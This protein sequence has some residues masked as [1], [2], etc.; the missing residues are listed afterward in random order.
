MKI[1]RKDLNIQKNQCMK[2]IYY[3]SQETDIQLA[4]LQ[5]VLRKITELRK[6]NR[7]KQLIEGNCFRMRENLVLHSVSFSEFYAK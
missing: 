3:G 6:S 7:K 1:K 5:A 4:N 2:I